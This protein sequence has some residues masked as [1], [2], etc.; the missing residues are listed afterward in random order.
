MNAHETHLLVIDTSCDYPAVG[1]HTAA[2]TVHVSRF[3]HA[4]RHGRDLLPA[5]AELL[6]GA[7]LSARELEVI[8]VGLGPGSYTGLR[9]GLTAARTL[10][11]ASGAD[12][13]G[14]DSLE[15]W[16]LSLHDSPECIHAVADAQRGD[17]YAA[18]FRRTLPEEPPATLVPARIVALDA[19]ARELSA[20]GIV[21]G[22]GLDSP[23]IRAAILPPVLQAAPAVGDSARVQALHRAGAEAARGGP[24][25]RPVDARAELPSSQCCR[26][27]QGR[28]AEEARIM[29]LSPMPAYNPAGKGARLHVVL[30]EPEI[31]SNTGAIGRTCVAAGASLWLVRPL[32]FHLDDRHLRRAG[33]DYWE[34]L[35]LCLADSLAEVTGALGRQRLWA[36]STRG[37]R[38]YTEAV[39]QPGDAL[40]FGPESRGLPGSWMDECPDRSLRIPIR[41]EARSL[42]LSSAV[43]IGLFEAVRQCARIITALHNLGSE[44]DRP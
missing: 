5:V 19:S 12:L 10:A 20:P 25:R 43:A 44:A 13:V 14:F 29:T 7:K 11:Y 40:V 26:R 39:F 27:D 21:V 37:S 31:A 41:P 17:V 32:G 4:R 2:G 15:G 35:D 22:P 9:I 28:A 6:Q 36:F 16:A 24:A 34:H 8:A 3:V 38:L 23:R 33:L 18:S 42:N 30:F 1:L